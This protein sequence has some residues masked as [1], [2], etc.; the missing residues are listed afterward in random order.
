MY[1]SLSISG[2]ITLE[3]HAL[4]NEGAEGNTMMTRMVDIIDQQGRKR[5]VNAISGDMFKHI[6]VEHLLNESK[7]AGLPLCTGCAVFN[8]SREPPRRSSSG[9]RHRATPSS[10]N[11]ALEPQASCR[12]CS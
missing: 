3:L 4:N 1:Q 12:P 10:R 2:L 6:V 9:S 11:T 7:T 5:S 8:A